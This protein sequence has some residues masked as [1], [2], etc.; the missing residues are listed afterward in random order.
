MRMLRGVIAV[1]VGVVLLLPTTPVRADTL[2]YDEPPHVFT[3]DVFI[4]AFQTV[5]NEGFGGTNLS[6]VELYNAGNV[7]VEV[8]SLRIEAQSVNGVVCELT[9]ASSGQYILPRSY[10]PLASVGALGAVC[11]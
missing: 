9:V 5:P 4:T 1:V 2:P 7:P 11:S 3:S 10:A 6:V 8:S